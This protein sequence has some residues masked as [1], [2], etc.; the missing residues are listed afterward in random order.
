MNFPLQSICAVSKFFGGQW[1]SAYG[2]IDGNKFVCLDNFYED[3]K[4]GE[5]LIYSFGV[6]GDWTFEEAMASMGCR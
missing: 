5:C 4:R 6:A 3:V 2:C 1:V